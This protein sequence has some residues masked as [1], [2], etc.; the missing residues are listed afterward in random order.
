MVVFPN[1]TGYCRQGMLEAVVG[2]RAG[3]LLFKPQL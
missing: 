3:L 2:R 1:S